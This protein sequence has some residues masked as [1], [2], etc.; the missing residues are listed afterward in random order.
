[1]IT[2]IILTLYVLIGVAFLCGIWWGRRAAMRG[3]ASMVEDE[4]CRAALHGEDVRA[5]QLFRVALELR[6]GR[7]L[8]A[9]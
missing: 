9:A 2:A 1:M 4:A 3:A 8:G 7:G 5:G 6:A